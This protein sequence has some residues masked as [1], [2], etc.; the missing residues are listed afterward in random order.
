MKNLIF[1]VVVAL[2]SFVA[3]ENAPTTEKAKAEVT[4]A[5]KSAKEMFNKEPMRW[6]NKIEKAQKQI[7]EQVQEL[8]NKWIE[9]TSE[10][11]KVE[12]DRQKRQLEGTRS[13]LSEKLDRLGE[14]IG[15]DWEAFKENLEETLQEAEKY[16]SDARSEF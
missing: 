5:G 14:D 6:K 3:C 15:D 10:E 16:V 9:T 12:I 1:L 4:Q 7:D 2:C 13:I 8:N 11:V